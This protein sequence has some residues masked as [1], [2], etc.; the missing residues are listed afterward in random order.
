MQRPAG[1]GRAERTVRTSASLDVVVDRVHRP[2]AVAV[3]VARHPNATH[4]P[5]LAHVYQAQTPGSK[6][7]HE[8]GK[9]TMPGGII[10]GVRACTCD[11]PLTP[12]DNL[13]KWRPG[14]LGPSD[15]ATVDP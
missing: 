15:S 8:E 5:Y 2:P 4:V 14:A 9:K 7:L 6:E 12:T 11:A 1:L 3:A 13:L 10:K